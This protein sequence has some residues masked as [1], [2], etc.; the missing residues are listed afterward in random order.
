[1][2]AKFAGQRILANKTENGSHGQF[3]S[4]RGIGESRNSVARE[5]GKFAYGILIA[6]SRY[7]GTLSF[8]A[9][10]KNENFSQ[11]S[12]ECVSQFT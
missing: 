2:Q 7:C 11:Q 4:Y 3:F 5:M 9:N 1:M 8:E 12:T 6:A 10:K